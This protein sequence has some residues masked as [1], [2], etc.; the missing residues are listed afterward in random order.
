MKNN[1]SQESAMSSASSR[2]SDSSPGGMVMAGGGGGGDSLPKTKVG[3]SYSASSCVTLR[4]PG[5]DAS[6]LRPRLRE[7]AAA[8]QQAK[9]AGQLPSAV[10]GDARANRLTEEEEEEMKNNLSPLLGGGGGLGLSDAIMRR[11]ASNNVLTQLKLSSAARSVQ[12]S[13]VFPLSRPSYARLTDRRLAL[14]GSSQSWFRN[15]KF[16]PPSNPLGVLAS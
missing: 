5:G 8:L 2:G 1:L 3:G 6:T 7:V 12:F 9:E 14:A 13:S 10:H 16:S 15:T 4:P 11:G